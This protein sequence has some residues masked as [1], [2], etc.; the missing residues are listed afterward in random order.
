MK[1]YLSVVILILLV[2]AAI[3]VTK[4]KG[5]NSTIDNKS[6]DFSITD[7][8]TV[9]QIIIS[10]KEGEK[11]V[12]KRE[13]NSRW[14]INDKYTARKDAVDLLLKT[15]NRIDVKAPVGKAGKANV[16]KAMAALGKSV[17]IY[18]NGSST[19]AKIYH[20]GTASA[21]QLGTY[22]VLEEDGKMSEDAYVMHIPG[23]NG[24]LNTRF[25]TE[26]YMWRDRLV[27][28]Y[29]TQQIGK[30]TFNN[31]EKPEASFSIEKNPGGDFT[32]FDQS[33]NKVETSQDI[34][35]DYL[36][37]YKDI[38][39]EVMDMETPKS[40][41]DSIIHSAG[42]YELT[43]SPIGGEPTKIH[44]YRLANK[45]GLTNTEGEPYP[46]DLDRMHALING[47]DFVYIQYPTFDK[48]YKEL[49]QFR[50]RI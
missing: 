44:T 45:A 26:E 42:F 1:K 33:G 20:I 14:T 3:F 36:I 32:L 28:N 11:A 50:P 39:W 23:F 22:M 15:F 18:T 19:P 7:T 24:Y 41:K 43:V 46:Y 48:L 10:T 4:W 47:V 6:S 27:F 8:S 35:K 34:I 25:F 49:D 29:T 16:L 38:Y 37:R 21:N 31:F 9:T 12:L 2:V 13:E 40:E 5:S 17:E 30:L